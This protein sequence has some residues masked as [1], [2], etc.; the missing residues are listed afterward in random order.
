M[1]T[2]IANWYHTCPN[3]QSSLEKEERAVHCKEC[4]FGF[5][6]NPAPCVTIVVTKD[7]KVLLAKRAFEPKKD[8]WN[9]PGGFIEPGETPIEATH[10]ELMEEISAKVTI[11]T[12]LGNAVPDVYSDFGDPTL[13]FLYLSELMGDQVQANDD[14]AELQ[15]MTLD[16]VPWD[17][18]AFNNDKI[19]LERYQEYRKE[20]HG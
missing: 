9:L 16:S 6:V 18:L 7:N 17:Q 11:I 3:C 19:A 8:M 10:R 12:E 1:H 14:V 13:N 4:G 15:W 5:Y 20:H 2:I